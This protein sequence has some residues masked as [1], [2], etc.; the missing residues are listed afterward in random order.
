MSRPTSSERPRSSGRTHTD[1]EWESVKQQFHYYY[2]QK[3]MSLKDAARCMSEDHGFDATLRQWERRIAPEKWGFSKYASRDER[4]KAIDA[5]G[6]TL[7]DVS[8]R[9]RRKSTASDGRPSLL[10]D[11]NL[12]RFARREV[13]RESRRPRA[14]SVSMLS[15]Q[16]DQDMDDTSTAASPAPSDY[17]MDT[18]E[19]PSFSQPD[20]GMFGSQWVV[21]SSQDSNMNI[22]QIRIFDQSHTLAVPQINIS[23]PDESY[24]APDHM[25]ISMQAQVNV[26]FPTESGHESFT[27]FHS[28]APDQFSDAQMQSGTFIPGDMARQLDPNIEWN[29]SIPSSQKQAQDFP[30]FAFDQ[31]NPISYTEMLQFGN[32]NLQNSIAGNKNH[33]E[34]VGNEASHSQ[35]SSED[36]GSDYEVDPDFEDPTYVDVFAVLKERDSKIMQMISMLKQTYQNPE[37]TEYAQKHIIN[38]INLLEQGIQAQSMS[39]IPCSVLY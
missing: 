28:P 21:E 24:I 35:Q 2:M 36:A 37:G 11:R 3:N 19:P 15:D 12:R 10:E 20:F 7:H 9:G 1:E 29:E 17:I 14:R 8:Q 23:G 33:H 27:S 25:P 4:L 5:S 13:S 26:H 22:P 38:S 30:S 6:K 16:S 18:Q 32:Q 34:H 31:N 39:T